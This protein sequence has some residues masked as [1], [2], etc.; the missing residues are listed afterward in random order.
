MRAI[1]TFK[2][3][4]FFLYLTVFAVTVSAQETVSR[5]IL[6]VIADQGIVHYQQI[7]TNN[8]DAPW[9][10][11]IA[12]RETETYLTVTNA[13]NGQQLIEYIPALDGL[14]H[15]VALHIVDIPTYE[16]PLLLTVWTRGVHGEKIALLDPALKEDALLFHRNFAWP[17]EFSIGA[18]GLALTF[19]ENK[20]SSDLPTN[21]TFRW[22][23]PDTISVIEGVQ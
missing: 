20:N 4:V 18:D 19:S 8:A 13:D 21:T 11:L 9:K 14:D 3:G 22:Q 16:H 12:K 7:F 2:T 5:P 15:F 1:K 17:I 23:S 10:I 6:S